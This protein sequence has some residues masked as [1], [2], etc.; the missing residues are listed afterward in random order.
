MIQKNVK[1]WKYVPE[2]EKN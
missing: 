1:L 2:L